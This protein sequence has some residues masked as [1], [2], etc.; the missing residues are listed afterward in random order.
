MSDGTLHMSDISR[1]MSSVS[2]SK[3]PKEIANMVMA[4]SQKQSTHKSSKL[5]VRKGTSLKFRDKKLSSEDMS[6]SEIP[7]LQYSIDGEKT[8]DIRRSIDKSASVSQEKP[9]NTFSYENKTNPDGEESD[10]EENNKPRHSVITPPKLSSENFVVDGYSPRLSISRTKSPVRSGRLDQSSDRFINPQ[11]DNEVPQVTSARQTEGASFSLGT[12]ASLSARSSMNDDIVK[13][14]RSPRV[15]TSGW[16]G[17]H[18]PDGTE[19]SKSSELHHVMSR[20]ELVGTEDIQLVD[21]RGFDAISDKHS[22]PQQ[23]PIQKRHSDFDP[24]KHHAMLKTQGNKH[25]HSHS[26]ESL[27]LNRHND[28]LTSTPV[29]KY[30]LI[31]EFKSLDALSKTS[32]NRHQSDPNYHKSESGDQQFSHTFPETLYAQPHTSSDVKSFY[33]T[34]TTSGQTHS[35]NTGDHVAQ[36]RAFNSTSSSHEHSTMSTNQRAIDDKSLMPPPQIPSFRHDLLPRQPPQD[37]PTLLTSESMLSRDFAKDYLVR[38]NPGRLINRNVH[39]KPLEHPIDSDDM[40]PH[41]DSDIPLPTHYDFMG[42]NMNIS[43][44]LPVYQSTPYNNRND[45]TI[46]TPSSMHTMMST[47]MMHELQAE[48]LTVME[49]GKYNLYV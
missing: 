42:D 49:D 23:I 33:T 31:G 6:L 25:K 27:A 26:A 5:P 35:Q 44:R 43:S 12:S 38:D 16:A 30:D 32:P 28:N 4:W 29:K 21:S 20:Q 8:K 2:M 18:I 17:H 11:R 48:N 45:T 47:G 34:Q 19:Y 9:L 46:I 22:L 13:D 15:N 1:F 37:K 40:L 39:P 24:K 10:K 36:N 7:E 3:D 14:G 41:R